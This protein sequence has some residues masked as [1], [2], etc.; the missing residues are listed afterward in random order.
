MIYEVQKKID[1]ISFRINAIQKC[2]KQINNI[3]LK[4]RLI[5]EYDDLKIK[6]DEIKSFVKFL[7]KS[8]SDKLSVSKV[9]RE[10]C[11]RCEKELFKNKELFSA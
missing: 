10:K 9:L 6:F 4:T 3:N 7:D 2:Y 1:K 5:N 11:D 8:S